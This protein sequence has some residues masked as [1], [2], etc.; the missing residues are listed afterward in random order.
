M[1]PEYD[2]WIKEHVYEC[3]GNCKLYA[4]EMAEAFPELIV[5]SGTYFRPEDSPADHWWCVTKEGEIIDPTAHQFELDRDGRPVYKVDNAN[6]TTDENVTGKCPRCGAW[7]Y[8]NDEYCSAKCELAAL[9][10][11]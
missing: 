11:V 4:Q 2:Q 5:V 9:R 8:D 6:Y 3:K 10:E 7:C 1:K